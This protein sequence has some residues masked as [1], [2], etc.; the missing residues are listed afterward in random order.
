MHTR[1]KKRCC[2]SA[3]KGT[4]TDNVSCDTDGVHTKEHSPTA[5]RFKRS[6]TRSN[7]GGLLRRGTAIFLL[8]LRGEETA[9]EE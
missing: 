9:A 3:E 7:Q 4:S 5:Q 1:T 8:D 2:Q 6:D